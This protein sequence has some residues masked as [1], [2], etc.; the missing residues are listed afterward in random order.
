MLDKVI[1]ILNFDNSVIRQKQL[2]SCYSSRITDL[3][4]FSG[5]ARLYCSASL[6]HKIS[7]LIPPA[8]NHPTFTGS[9]DFHHISE[10][11]TSRIGS[12]ATLVVFDFHPDWDGLPPRFGCG[13]WV[14]QALKNKNITKCILI[15][16]GSQDLNGPALQSAG[17]G[18][19][20]HNRLEIYPYRHS[21]SRV[22]LRKVASNYSLAAKK[23]FFSTQI[24]WSQLENTGLAQFTLGL[25]KR[26]PERRVYISI[27]KDCLTKDFA[28]TNWEEGCLRLEQLLTM[29]RVLRENLEIIGLDVTGDYSAPCFSGRIKGW[30]SRLDHPRHPAAQGFTEEEILRVNEK[31]NLDILQEIFA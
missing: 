26:L 22:Y 20:A 31:T 9:G 28:L 5:S 25:I 17:L 27:D 6:R 2:L 7:S 18:A 24:S 13:S 3:T 1:R 21:P 8:E 15:G 12:P 30:V 29:L 14:T 23:N 16:M 11:L 10:I 4:G 19:L